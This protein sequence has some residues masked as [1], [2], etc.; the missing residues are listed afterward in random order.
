M[1]GPPW[2]RDVPPSARAGDGHARYAAA[3]MAGSR[4]ASGGGPCRRVNPNGGFEVMQTI[5]AV[6]SGDH[7]QCDSSFADMEE[8]AAGGDWD[9]L[10]GELRDFDEA[11]RRHLDFEEQIL[12]P[13]LQAAGVPPGPTEVMLMEHEQMR[14][15]LDQLGRAAAGQDSEEF[16]G[17]AETLLMLIQQHN[18]KEEQVL[19][20]MADELLPEDKR[21][22]VLL[23]IAEWGIA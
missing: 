5:T 2:H 12:F 21:Q 7:A 14:E 4:G 19:Y 15:L 23:Q 1:P 18:V 11:M 13:T 3:A 6:M 10:E 20:H 8:A 22:E 16:M 9:K 17:V